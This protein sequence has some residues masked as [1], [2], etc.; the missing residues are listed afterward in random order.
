[1]SYELKEVVFATNLISESKSYY[2][3]ELNKK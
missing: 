2:V 3:K 1:M